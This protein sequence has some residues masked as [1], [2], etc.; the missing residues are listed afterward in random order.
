MVKKSGLSLFLVAVVVGGVFAQTDFELLPRT[1]VTVDFG[2][3][4]IGMAF[5]Q[6]GK[7]L[8]NDDLSSSGFGIAAQYER[9]IS[10]QVSLAGRFTYLRAGWGFAENG[11]IGI[12]TETNMK[13]TS[14]SLEG[15]ARYYPFKGN[16]FFLD[17]MLGYATMSTDLS[18]EAY[19]TTSGSQNINAI[20]FTAK[21]NYFKLGA[22][23]GWRIDFGTPGGLIF[24]PSFGYYYGFGL[25][26]TVGKQLSKKYG[27]NVEGVDDSFKLIE[28]YVFVGGPQLSLSVGW[29]F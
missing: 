18:G 8:G 26:D 17:G 11:N 16:T 3:T 10:E 2:P 9:Q 1:T 7:I 15:H 6:A 14:Y 28:K 23:V 4:I 5:G 20:E 27:G 19:I 24:E 25:G 29:R 12:R 13:I 21:R 22:K